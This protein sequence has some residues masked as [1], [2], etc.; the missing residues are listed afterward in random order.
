MTSLSLQ[1]NNQDTTYWVLARDDEGRTFVG[2]LTGQ[3]GRQVHRWL[4]IDGSEPHRLFFE[5]IPVICFTLVADGPVATD[6]YWGKAR[7]SLYKHWVTYRSVVHHYER[8]VRLHV[9]QGPLYMA[10]SW[11]QQGQPQ[12]ISFPGS[13]S[14]PAAYRRCLPA[15]LIQ[16]GVC[17]HVYSTRRFQRA[18][19][20]GDKDEDNNNPRGLRNTS[21]LGY[22]GG[23]GGQ[24]RRMAT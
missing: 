6:P 9:S 13:T 12:L 14:F 5:E 7:L 22:L 24:K 15:T 21:D 19:T 1:Q 17:R 4:Q 16:A 2:T 3:A 20:D 18:E 11:S 23:G 8:T 10:H